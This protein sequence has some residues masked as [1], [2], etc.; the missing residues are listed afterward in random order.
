MPATAPEN[1]RWIWLLLPGSRYYLLALVFFVVVFGIIPFSIYAHSGDD[2]GFPFSELLSVAALG[3]ALFIGFA[4]L[5]RLVAALHAHAASTAAI[6]L[7]CLGVFL[8]L[9]HVYAPIQIAP[10]DGREI[11]SAEPAIYSVV[12]LALLA[13]LILVFVQLRRR[14]GLSIAASFSVALILVAIAYAGVLASGDREGLEI[15]EAPAQTVPTLT[16]T[17]SDIDG[18]IYHIVL[19][20]MQTDAFLYALERASQAEDFQGFELF[21]K[22]VSN[23]ISTVPSSASY[24]TGTLYKAGEFNDWGR[25]WQKSRGLLATLSERGYQT[26]MYSA[27]RNWQNKYIDHYQYAV[28]IYEQESGFANAGLYDLLHIWLASLAPNLLTNEALPLAATLA[29]PTFELVTGRLRPLSG[30]EGLHQ[31]AGVLMLRRLVREES[32]RASDR[33]YVYA[34]VQL[35]H[36][37]HVLDRDCRY[38]GPTG[39]RAE[40]IRAKTGYLLQA[41][42]ALGLVASFLQE[43]RRL[44]RYQMATIVIHGDTGDWIRL[45]KIMDR[46]GKILDYPEAN[47]LSYVQAVLMIKRPHAEGPLRILDTPTQLVD[48]FPTVLDLLDLQPSYELDGRSVYSIRE[49]ERREARVGFDP[50]DLTNG[51]NFVEVR[52]EDQSDLPRSP[53]TII[54][55][56]VEA[57]GAELVKP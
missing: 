30:Q 42:C 50:E 45:G 32:L 11:E 22:N 41:E 4:V 48:L 31:A 49:S 21:R 51:R 53:L 29:D 2:W 19:D 57:R 39:R 10:L 47:L 34:H 14:R 43:L 12:E 16:T 38:V 33:V 52:I 35:P 24:F 7:F 13:A 3:L 55:P 9:A 36:G 25:A 18:N 5:I 23:Y 15:A 20:R 8:L 54:G 6:A 37:P 1:R 56:V 40:P 27:L 46:R 26:W 17:S 28:D 44:G